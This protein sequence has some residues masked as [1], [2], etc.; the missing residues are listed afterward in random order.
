M[1]ISM[2]HKIYCRH[3]AGL[4]VRLD[5]STI[6][7]AV[8]TALRAELADTP[9]E[10]FVLIVDDA[11]IR[12][13]NRAHRGVDLATDVL[14]FPQQDLTPGRFE[15]PALELEANNGFLQL[16]DIVVSSERVAVQ[17]LELRQTFR[18]ETAYLIVHSVLH[19]LGYDHTDEG[20]DKRLMRE[21][22]KEIMSELEAQANL[23]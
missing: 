13:L 17:A 7:S 16:G 4:A 9:C 23:F 6:R 22:E 10:L 12:E 1:V 3:V 18:R 21:R 14:S 5:I 15:P 20:A 2:K 19:L 11:R 8:R